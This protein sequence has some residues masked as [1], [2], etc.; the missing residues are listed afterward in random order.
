MDRRD[1]SDR[2]VENRQGNQLRYCRQKLERCTA[3]SPSMVEIQLAHAF[4]PHV[5]RDRRRPG[6][7]HRDSRTVR[8]M[9]EN[10]RNSHY[11]LWIV[12]HMLT[13][14]S[15]WVDLVLEIQDTA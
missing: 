6:P 3:P 5:L 15:D 13:V 10:E 4:A 8:T 2:E 11:G 1:V 7:R 12:E 14:R 9:L